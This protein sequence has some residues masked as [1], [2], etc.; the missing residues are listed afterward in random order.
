MAPSGSGLFPL[1]QS[2]WDYSIIAGGLRLT[3]VKD[4]YYSTGSLSITGGSGPRVVLPHRF[5]LLTVS[6]S[7][8]A[9]TVA[10]SADWIRITVRYD[11]TAQV[12]DVFVNGALAADRIPVAASALPDSAASVLGTG[13]LLLIRGHT[14]YPTWVDDVQATATNPC[15]N[16]ADLDG[17]SDEI[18]VARGTSPITD[19]RAADA[20]G[21]TLANIT[22][23][24]YG[25]SPSLAD[26]DGD[27]MPDA[28]E[29][30]HYLDPL[31]PKDALYDLEGDGANNL[32]EFLAGTDPW[33]NLEANTVSPSLIY[34]RADSLGGNGT[35]YDP[36]DTIQTALSVLADGGTIVLDGAGGP[37]TGYGNQGI[38]T[39]K[40]FRLIGTNNA[41]V[42]CQGQERFL[43]IGG[44]AS[45]TYG[46]PP[47][48]WDPSDPCVATTPYAPA[49]AGHELRDLTITGSAGWGAAI[50]CNTGS[51]LQ[52]TR[53][54]FE[55][56]FQTPIAVY[57]PM[58]NWQLSYYLNNGFSYGPGYTSPVTITDSVF[59]GNDAG[60]ILLDSGLGYED[61][62]G[63]YIH[64]WYPAIS[65]TVS[66]SR[67]E[68]NTGG[69]TIRINAAPSSFTNCLWRGNLSGN[70]GG[71]IK[72]TSPSM[73]LLTHCTIT[74]RHTHRHLRDCFLES[75]R[76]NTVVGA[77][78]SSRF[79]F[80]HP[81]GQYT[82]C[83]HYR[84][85]Q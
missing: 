19:D 14:G 59:H 76:L 60:A 20:D 29:I 74:G 66:G 8:G 69:P 24:R 56:N 4:I 3:F 67:F 58:A 62:D 32:E 48:E 5:P 31:R 75:Q 28:W 36:F 22:E 72:A 7:G 16:D 63:T 26:T 1:S 2:L 55:N 12:S 83:P 84:P 52:I 73:P 34:I 64:Y 10:Q 43:I 39:S 82:G 44:S 30:A 38:Y 18:E 17:M 68:W 27:G 11:S 50:E 37:F 6:S 46:L 45:W 42:D 40:Y 85:H 21:D 47:Q 13:G 65:L 81:L 57:D 33:D 41:V 49:V 51:P 78:L 54:R 79:P 25:T 23:L 71:I 9:S 15:F 35:Q 70:G 80:L 77:S 53:C 61:W